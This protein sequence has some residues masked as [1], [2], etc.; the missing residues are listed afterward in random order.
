[1]SPFVKGDLEGF[2]SVELGVGL[3]EK[4]PRIRAWVARL[5]QR[6]GPD[7]SVVVQLECPAIRSIQKD[8]SLCSK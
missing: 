3:P 1:M 6:P 8:F 5:M 7:Y 4:Y 2:F